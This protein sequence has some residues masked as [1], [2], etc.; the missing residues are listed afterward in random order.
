MRNRLKKLLW[1]ITPHIHNLPHVI[2]IRWL[3][4]EWFIDKKIFDW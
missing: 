2:Y 3:Y 4:H 1:E